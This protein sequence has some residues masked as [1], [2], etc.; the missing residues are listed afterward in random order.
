MKEFKLNLDIL[1]INEIDRQSFSIDLSN[2]LINFYHNRQFFISRKTYNNVLQWLKEIKEDII[3]DK[4]DFNIHINL[5][6]LKH[7]DCY[8]QHLR[9]IGETIDYVSEICSEALCTINSYI[10]LISNNAKKD[11]AT[12]KVI[13]E[14]TKVPCNGD[15]EIPML[16]DSF[17]NKL[18][19]IFERDDY[20]HIGCLLTPEMCWDINTLINSY[21]IDNV[22]PVVQDDISRCTSELLYKVKEYEL[23]KCKNR[24]IL[25]IICDRIKLLWD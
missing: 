21:Y 22:F 14:L 8:Y 4:E 17:L 20:V 12:V 15:D 5:I 19:E 16:S 6:K 11:K 24:S 3:K 9:D 2:G 25:S 1:N 13:T 18:G 10:D 7:P 23:H